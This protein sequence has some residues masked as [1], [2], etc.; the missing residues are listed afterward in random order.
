MQHLP[1]ASPVLHVHRRYSC[2]RPGLAGA[3]QRPPSSIKMTCKSTMNTL[4]PREGASP[5]HLCVLGVGQRRP[6]G[7]AH[8]MQQQPK[9][10][11]PFLPLSRRFVPSLSTD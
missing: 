10:R 1:P 4:Q 9:A 7:V 3:L 11:Q 2:Q 5:C 6:P 8:L